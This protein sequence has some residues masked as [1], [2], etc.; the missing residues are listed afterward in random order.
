MSLSLNPL[1]SC[2][3]FS[4]LSH[5]TEISF[6]ARISIV[7]FFTL[8]RHCLISIWPLN[9]TKFILS[10]NKLNNKPYSL[11]SSH[12][13]L[14]VSHEKDITFNF[15]ERNLSQDLTGIQTKHY[16]QRLNILFQKPK[17]LA[18]IN[19]D[20]LLPNLEANGFSKIQCPWYI[21]YTSNKQ[22]T[23]LASFYFYLVKKIF[24]LVF[25]W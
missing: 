21:A 2:V 25:P 12:S 13:F 5:L 16:K 7:V 20:L 3:N 4:R 14:E 24:S 8:N 6:F 18:S 11:K 15:I 23:V 22:P 9:K 1:P 10:Y 17:T 19:H